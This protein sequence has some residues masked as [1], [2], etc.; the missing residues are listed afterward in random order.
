MPQ[1]SFV[2]RVSGNSPRVVVEDVRTREKLVADSLAE[3]G[4]H[5]ERWLEGGDEPAEPVPAEEEVDA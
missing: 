4:E 2:V 3:V 1:R 5:I